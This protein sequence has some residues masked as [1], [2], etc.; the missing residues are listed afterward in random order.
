M[1]LNT[2]NISKMIQDAEHIVVIQAE[3]PDGDSLASSLALEQ[4]LADKK[5]TM[6]CPVTIPRHLRHMSGWDRVENELP[7]SFDLSIIVDTSSASLMEKILTPNQAPILKSKPILVIDH[8]D[9]ESTLPFDAEMAL[10]SDAVSTGEVIYDISKDLD[11][12]INQEAAE[13][14]ASSI[15]YDSL[16]L[17]ASG[18]TANS[19]RVIADLVEQG[20]SLAKLDDKRRELMRRSQ[21]LTK[22]KG[23]LIQRIDYSL[24]GELAL[25]TIP[26]EEIEKYSDQYNPS[27]LVIEDMRLTLPVKVALAFKIYKDGKITAK[28][29]AN[30]GFGVADKI[31]E[32][33]GGGGH[34][35]AAG[36][37]V[38]DKKLED[39]KEELND[40]ARKLFDEVSE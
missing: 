13:F 19:I 8:H 32:H 34:K 35:Y 9:T 4:I 6:Y 23:E 38:R 40:V 27:M 1:S 25:I 17:I 21:E 2:D 3:N 14:L 5:I 22:Y 12:N 37:K 36:F 33:F 18:T 10:N 29:R 26:W 15:M 11:W 7:R 16:G 20:V 28:L 31:A 24:D 39:I 30:H